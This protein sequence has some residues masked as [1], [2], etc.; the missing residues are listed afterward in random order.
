MK[1]SPTFVLIITLLVLPMKS[2]ISLRGNLMYKVA[3]NPVPM[4]RVRA[5]G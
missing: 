1:E 2:V 4:A 3:I 5:K